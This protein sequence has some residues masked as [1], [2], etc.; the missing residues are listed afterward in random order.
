VATRGQVRVEHLAAETGW[1]RKRL[2]SRFGAQIGLGPKRA[3][4]LVWFDHAAHGLAA[5]CSAAR[6]AAETGYADQS[7]LHR[8]VMAF[9][10]VTP[11][12]V[13]AAPWLAVDHIAWATPARRS[14]GDAAPPPR[15]GG[16][17]QESADS[18]LGSQV[19]P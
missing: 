16:L 5:G 14:P 8:E 19:R 7:H 9:A 2:W 10:G 15:R 1:S 12:A 6:V 18:A 13:A 11:A 4:E 3:A 17:S